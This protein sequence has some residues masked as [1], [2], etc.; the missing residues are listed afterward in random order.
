LIYIGLNINCIFTFITM[1]SLY[2]AL[3]EC[4]APQEE[5]NAPV[6][7]EQPG[8][9][10]FNTNEQCLDATELISKSSIKELSAHFIDTTNIDMRFDGIK[11]SYIYAPYLEIEMNKMDNFTPSRIIQSIALYKDDIPQLLYYGSE[12][13][14]ITKFLGLNW[15][16]SNG[17][18]TIPLPIERENVCVINEELPHMVITFNSRVTC[19]FGVYTGSLD[20]N[21]INTS[22]QIRVQQL[23][24]LF[25]QPSM[26]EMHVNMTENK[27]IPCEGV[28]IYADNANAEFNN[29]KHV[30]VKSND[31]TINFDDINNIRKESIMHLGLENVYFLYFENNVNTDKIQIETDVESQ[32]IHSLVVSWRWRDNHII[33]IDNSTHNNNDQ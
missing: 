27:S 10:I 24:K 5:L 26:F 33:K 22:N 21:L 9:I 4:F 30:I 17:K 7:I 3:V 15:G 11:Y 31:Q 6:K 32:N 23:F 19:T 29:I 13:D 20:A 28:L 16:Y 12:I 14:I 18:Y 25:I 2:S 8:K 1:Y